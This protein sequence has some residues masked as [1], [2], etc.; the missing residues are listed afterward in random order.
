MNERQNEEI[1]ILYQYSVVCSKFAW[2][3][4]G[5]GQTVATFFKIVVRSDLQAKIM[6][7]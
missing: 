2:V 6:Q 1:K 5:L 7:S 3:V 4:G